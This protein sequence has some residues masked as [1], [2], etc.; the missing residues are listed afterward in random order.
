MKVYFDG[1]YS[2]FC[3]MPQPIRDALWDQFLDTYKASIESK[4]GIVSYDQP[5]F[6]PSSWMNAINDPSECR[7]HGYPLHLV[8]QYLHMMKSDQLPSSVKSEFLTPLVESYIYLTPLV[9][10]LEDQDLD[11]KYRDSEDDFV[12]RLVHMKYADEIRKHED[13]DHD[14]DQDQDHN[15]HDSNCE[16]IVDYSCYDHRYHEYDA[17]DEYNDD[18]N[19]DDDFQWRI[20]EFIGM[21]K[22]GWREE[23]L[24]ER[25]LLYM[26]SESSSTRGSQITMA[27]FYFSST[28]HSHSPKIY[29]YAHEQ[30]ADKWQIVSLYG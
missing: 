5:D 6:D 28:S 26:L 14:Q 12:P 9:F 21:M 15:N 30:V 18:D 24:E 20:E 17:D 4:Y 25:R 19:E 3:S 16:E 7:V 23:M 22:R 1:P 11:N 8:I 27:D 29:H 2:T 13:H 10:A